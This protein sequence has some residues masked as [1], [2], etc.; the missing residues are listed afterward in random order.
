VD[1]LLIVSDPTLRGIIAAARVVEVVDELKTSV[2]A[3]YLIVNRVNGDQLPA[4][5]MKAIREHRLELAGLVPADPAVTELD[6]LGEPVIKLPAD[7]RSRR[8][9]EAILTS[10]KGGL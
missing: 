4:P 7:A 6:G 8:S 10:V 3:A 9:L 1:L 2:G 5:L